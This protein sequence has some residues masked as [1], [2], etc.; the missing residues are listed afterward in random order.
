MCAIS[1]AV[2]SAL[3]VRTLASCPVL[4]QDVTPSHTE[5]VNRVMDSPSF[6]TAVAA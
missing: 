1:K 5:T 6:K 2:L 3:G 4:A